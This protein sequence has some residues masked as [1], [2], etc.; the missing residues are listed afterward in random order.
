MR[1]KMKCRS[2]TQFDDGT[3]NVHMEAV[4]NGS[5]ENE[6]FFKHTSSGFFDVNQINPEMAK[7][8]AAGKEYFI[9]ITIAE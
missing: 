6:G 7:Q 1:L 9:D 5:K 8:F 2:V 4:M 3:A